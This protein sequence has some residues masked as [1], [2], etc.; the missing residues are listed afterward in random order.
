MIQYLD[1]FEIIRPTQC[2]DAVQDSGFSSSGFC[3]PR[4]YARLDNID[5]I[6]WFEPRTCAVERDVLV[7]GMP[8]F[9]STE[10][11]TCVCPELRVMV[12]ICIQ[13]LARACNNSKILYSVHVLENREH[14]V[15]GL[16]VGWKSYI[17]LNVF[18]FSFPLV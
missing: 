8:I 10:L 1:G 9:R 13:C 12:D 5:L 18:L 17:I 15:V 11:F 6:V 4:A 16:H 2:I 3:H 7:D 14:G